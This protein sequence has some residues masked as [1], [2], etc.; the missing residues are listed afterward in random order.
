[1]YFCLRWVEPATARPRF[2]PDRIAG[3]DCHYCRAHFS[4]VAGCP[5]GSRSRRRA[6]CVNNLKQLALAAANYES[7]TNVYPPGLY[8]CLL[9]GQYAG[10]LGTNCGPM[11]HLTPYM[12][13]GQV[14]NAVN[15]LED[16]YYNSNLTA[17]AIGMSTLWCPSDGTIS[18]VQTLGN[19]SFFETVV[20]PQS[21]RMA[22]SSYGGMVGPW[23]VN[24]WSIPGVGTGARS[25]HG[26][27]KSNQFGMFNVCSDVRLSSVTDGTSNTMVFAEHAH[28][29]L[30]QADQ[31]SWQWW[32]SGNLGDTLVTTMW[33]LNPHR[34]LQDQATGELGGKI[35][36]VSASS[37]HPGGANFAFVDG[38]VRF[39]KDSIQSWPLFPIGQ[40]LG[41]NALP[42]SVQASFTGGRT[43]PT[44]DQVYNV[45]PGNQFG[46]YQALSTR[47]QGEIT[48]S[49][50]Y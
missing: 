4:P 26:A 18:E 34:K 20:A 6:Q 27:I 36:I 19:D 16:I 7:A 28:G 1:M 42:V 24:T 41:G 15:F 33:P 40:D 29:L 25:T 32:D 47:N 21:A 9:T 17:H 37:F 5:V 31:P 30:T 8:W 38:S 43:N 12:E 14:Y 11:V 13:Q 35:F 50:S 46:V 44:W 22:Y 45:T 39:L 2:H 10:F 3:S 48:S 49:D 23:L